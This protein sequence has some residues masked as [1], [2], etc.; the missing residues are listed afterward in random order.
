MRVNKKV[1]GSIGFLFVIAIVFLTVYVAQQ[2]QQTQQ[3]AA[4]FSAIHDTCNLITL[5]TQES[6]ICPRLTQ[7]NNGNNTCTVP[8]P[9]KKNTNIAE[10]TYTV[11]LSSNDGK[12]HTIKYRY[13]TNFCTHGY[14][15]FHGSTRDCHCNDNTQSSG[16][17]AVTIDSL[18]A[19]T[20]QM[21]R[22]PI[23]GYASCG[24]YQFDLTIVSVDGRTSCSL[25]PNQLG[26]TLSVGHCDTGIDCTP[27]TPTPIPSPT[28]TPTPQV[29]PTR[30]PSPS[31]VVCAT[32]GA[33][34]NI[35]ITCPYC[36]STTQA[37]H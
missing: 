37:S 28:P 24:A 15:D 1:L 32:P 10:Y 5:S 19:K 14:G 22:S 16:D 4:V 25:K 26:N 30:I 12:Q 27:V 18:N 3:N 2:T 8:D 33:V 9:S 35:K 7:S 31:S 23:Q 34:K 6:P 21:H 20:I 36:S 17:Q 13:L 11:T 29:P